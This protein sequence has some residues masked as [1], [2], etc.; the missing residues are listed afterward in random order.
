MAGADRWYK[1]WVKANDVLMQIRKELDKINI[2]GDKQTQMESCVK[3]I[4]QLLE[5]YMEARKTDLH[6]EDE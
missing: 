6:E 2:W 5:D 1:R 3:N 4:N